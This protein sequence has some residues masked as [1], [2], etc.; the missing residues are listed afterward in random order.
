MSRTAQ[1]IF[2]SVA[3][4][5]C[6]GCMAAEVPLTPAGDGHDTVPVFVNSHGPYP[7]ILDTGADGPAVYQWFALT[8]RLKKLP[9]GESLTG[10]TGS[11]EVST[12]HIA[13]FELAGVHQRHAT[14]VG[15]P[16]RHDAGREA[17]VL[18]NDFMDGAVV[19]FDFP[20]HKIEVYPKPADIAAVVGPGQPPVIAGTSKN[21]TLLSL[22]VTINGYTGPALLDTGSRETRLNFAFAHAAGLDTDS[23]RFHDAKPIYGTSGHKLVPRIGTVNSIRFAG[24]TLQNTT[25]QIADL[26]ALQE[27]FGSKPAMLLGAD[28]LGHYRLIYDHSS[29]RIWLRTSTCTAPH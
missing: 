18:G 28:L 12:Y 19:A 25:I 8:A 21:D 24:T 11:S 15:L 22:P 13:D 27:D 17:G 26:P 7:F 5:T 29:H 16:D 10:Q 4:F 3:V 9:G 20:C 2:A 6:I 14:A 23:A 1:R